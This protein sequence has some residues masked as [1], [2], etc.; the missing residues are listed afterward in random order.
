MLG[1]RI[2]VGVAAVAGA[3][4]FTACGSTGSAAA[5]ASNAGP[6]AA[7]APAPAEPAPAEPAAAKTSGTPRCTTADLSVSLGKPKEKSP[8]QFDIPLTYRNVSDHTCGLHGVPGVDLAGPEDPT[9][10][11]VYHLPRVD[12]G[13]KHNEVTPGTTAS[14]TITVLTP[15]EGGASWTPAKLTTI[16]PGQTQP[17][18][19]DW[20]ADLPV[21]RQDAATHPG[22]YVNGILADP[23]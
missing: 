11:P 18:T 20:P 8:G 14:A 21:L 2:S 3:F 5:P 17:L 12:N 19:A 13:V 23:A 7:A 4:A 16:P 15:A 10:G 1:K 6:G 9:F 22:S